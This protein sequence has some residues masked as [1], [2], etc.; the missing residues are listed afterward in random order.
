MLIV[1]IKG[2][3]DNLDKALKRFK[4][5]FEKTGVVRT[6]RAGQ[7]F[8]KPSIRRRN[9]VKHAAYVQQLQLKAEDI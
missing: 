3:N 9:Q 8:T 5:K 7:F 6:L 2:D 1:P 4:R